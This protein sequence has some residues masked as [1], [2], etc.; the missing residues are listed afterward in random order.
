MVSSVCTIIPAMQSKNSLA[1]LPNMI[2][3]FNFFSGFLSLLFASQGKFVPAAWLIFIAFIWDSLDG[4]VA[5][6]FNNPTPLGKELDSLSDLVSFVVAPS[7]LIARFLINDFTPWM[8]LF[9]FVYLTCGA[10]RLARFNLR[11]GG[12]NYFE[13]LPTPA[14]A[15][16]VVSV[17]LSC[18]K[19]GWMEKSFFG[20]VVVSMMVILGVLMVSTIH[21]PKFSAIPFKKWRSMVWLSIVMLLAGFFLGQ[22]EL[23]FASIQF[24]FIF[25]S[26]IYNISFEVGA[27]LADARKGGDKPRPYN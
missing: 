10:L 25:V 6:M 8:L 18:V 1:F 12:K 11:P 20:M 23:A 15:L 26:P 4:N 16:A 14:A 3:L 27:S 13:G 21:Y 2:T 24:V 5:R 19:N 17:L 7:F 9:I 22:M